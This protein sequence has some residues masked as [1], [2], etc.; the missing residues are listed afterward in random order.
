[1]TRPSGSYRQLDVE[2]TIT[3]LQTLRNRI[4]ERFDASSLSR[5][6]EELCDIAGESRSRIHWIE[7]PHKGLRLMLGLVIIAAIALAAF[8]FQEVIR[9]EGRIGLSDLEWI[10]NEILL[11][12]AA[13]LFL[14]GLE[15]RVK[16]TRALHALHDLR[17]IAH[18]IDMHQLT[19]DPS[20]I[21]NPNARPTRSSPKR[22]LTPFLLTRYLDYCS[23]MLSLL[24]KLS[25]LYAQSL[26]DPVVVA[27]V[28][29]I[30]TLANGLSRKIWQKIVML[31]DVAR[32]VNAPDGESTAPRR[33]DAS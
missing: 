14:F 32:L 1:M 29:D 24:G 10:T 25:A 21:L 19:K 8:G 3:T 12:G 18:V 23:E 15:V 27:A 13:L 4:R 11:L 33:T 5:V 20:Q 16:R 31:D 26:P 6:A 7:R 2:K 9:I 30:E 28:N 22:V 17:A